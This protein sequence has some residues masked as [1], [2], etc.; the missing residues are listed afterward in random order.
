MKILENILIV[1]DEDDI[2]EVIILANKLPYRTFKEAANGLEALALIKEEK[3]SAIICDI[4]MPKISGIEVFTITRDMGITTPFI[5]LSGHAGE[6]I[7]SKIKNKGT[8]QFVE[9]T[10][11]RQLAQIISEIINKDSL[12]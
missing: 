6:D 10:N 12:N 8:V 3:F 1:D 5:F 7:L 2:R 11:I 4:S 9:K